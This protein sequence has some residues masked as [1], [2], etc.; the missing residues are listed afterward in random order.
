MKIHR[1]A[2]YAWGTLV[3]NI[4]VILWG[5]FVRS[6]GSGAG[7]GTHWPLCHGAVIPETTHHTTFIE[8]A[9]RIS[10]GLAL[11][12]VVGLLT[13]GLYHYPRGSLVRWG[14]GFALLFM[15]IEALLGAGLVL[16]EL[17]AENA[18]VAR[19]VWMSLHLV[20]IFWLLS[21]LALC[22]WWSS[23]GRMNMVWPESR[24]L[25]ALTIALG[26]T[27]LLSTSGALT[28]LSDTLFP[29][30][31]LAAGFQ[32]DLDPSAHFLVRLRPL[33]PIVAVLMSFYLIVVAWQFYERRL[34]ARMRWFASLLTLFI[35]MQL[36]TGVLNVV[37]L[38][39]TAM[40][41][42][43]LLLAMLVWITLVLLT[44]EMLADRG[45]LEARELLQMEKH[46]FRY[47]H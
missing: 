17:V 16:F 41:I 10:S 1:F 18:S 39:P 22:A 20:N 25:L 15:V 8:F 36:I 12:L 19:A 38:A 23:G 13:W 5:A 40:Q 35:A 27:L 26:G 46:S 31:S 45:D 43:H 7:C 2:V 34:T 14:A 32:Q 21:C 47:T 30:A 37:L 33:H 42:I 11:L 44:S 29:V 6:S 28:A 4:A 24:T 9:H 3:Y